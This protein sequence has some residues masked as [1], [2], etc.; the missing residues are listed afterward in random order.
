[1]IVLR[2]KEPDAARP[3]RIPFALGWVPL[4]PVAALLV[5]LAM[6][7]FLRPESLALGAGALALGVVAYAIFVR[8]RLARAA[9]EAAGHIM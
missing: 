1:M 3:F 6:A 5:A 9:N 8:P 7:V 2:R 4:A